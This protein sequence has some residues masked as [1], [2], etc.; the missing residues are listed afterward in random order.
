MFNFN[1]NNQLLSANATVNALLNPNP[2]PTLNPN[3]EIDNE[4]N[5][6]NKTMIIQ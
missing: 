4:N 1:V 3:P 6:T 2:T 5:K